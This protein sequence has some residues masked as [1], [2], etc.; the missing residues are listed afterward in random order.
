MDMIRRVEKLANPASTLTFLA[1]IGFICSHRA[2]KSTDSSD[3]SRF[4][5]NRME[6]AILGNW[7]SSDI[8]LERDED[9]DS[10]LDSLTELELDTED[11][12]WL[13]DCGL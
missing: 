11:C 3:V 12:A 8:R 6:I 7:T 9:G 13:L 10:P 5:S 1:S 4:S 2:S